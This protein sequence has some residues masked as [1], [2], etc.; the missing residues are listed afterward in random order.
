MD[1]LETIQ[2]VQNPP[3]MHSSDEDESAENAIVKKTIPH[4]VEIAKLFGELEHL[5]TEC[6]VQDALSHLRSAKRAFLIAK[7]IRKPSQSRQ[8]LITECMQIGMTMA[9][10]NADSQ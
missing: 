9:R 3:E 1:V 10:S 7:H 4:V 8:A 6:Q 2:V 5:A